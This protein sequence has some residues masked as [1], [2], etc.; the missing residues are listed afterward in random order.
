MIFLHKFFKL[1]S[2]LKIDSPYIIAASCV[3][4]AAKV[5]YMPITLN[6]AVEAFFEIEKRRNPSQLNRTILSEE[7]QD[8]Y[9]VLFIQNESLVLNAIGYD[10]ECE[11]PYKYLD[12]FCHK[13]LPLT[14]RD[15]IHEL[16]VKFCNDSF[17]LPLCLYYH[18]KIIAASCIHMA[19]LWRKNKGFDCGI[20]L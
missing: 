5:R 11:A 3:F 8:H 15:S 19:A 17:K 7:R 10:F 4:L 13:H 9:R 20:P 12:D 1:N 2:L 18:P 6:K 16:A 14:S